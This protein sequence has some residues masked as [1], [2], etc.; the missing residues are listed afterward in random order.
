M[1]KEDF[2]IVICCPSDRENLVAEIG[3]KREEWVEISAETPYEYVIQFYNKRSGDY[4]E[5]P[6]DEAMEVL[7]EAKN[8]LAKYQR[9]PEEQAEYDAEQKAQDNFNPNS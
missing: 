5:F 9:T 2:R 6:Y 3:Y 4:W 7:E 1:S 8:R